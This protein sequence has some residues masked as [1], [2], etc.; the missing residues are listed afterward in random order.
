MSY[1]AP[2]PPFQVSQGERL[3][4]VSPSGQPP[5]F[6]HPEIMIVETHEKLAEMGAKM[7]KDL[8]ENPTA[9]INFDVT[10]EKVKQL[11]QDVYNR[12]NLEQK[13]TMSAEKI[14]PSTNDCLISLIYEAFAETAI[15]DAQNNPENILPFQLSI[16]SRFRR[17]P[18]VSRETLGNFILLAVLDITK[19][20]L[21]K[22]S[23][24]DLAFSM[25][26]RVLEYDEKYVQ[27]S[28]DKIAINEL[29]Q[30]TSFWHAFTL[31]FTNWNRYF[32][33]YPDSDLGQGPPEKFGT[34]SRMFVNYCVVK[35]GRVDGYLD[36]TIALHKPHMEKFLEHKN[37]KEYLQVS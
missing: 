4:H 21:A 16:N 8:I 31:R 18:P 19:D 14:Y 17:S 29:S 20:D 15:D 28:I 32:D 3:K 23:S 7:M 30:F 27:S 6:E 36:L 2:F 9:A 22:M 13:E 12:A 37:V 34:C 10:P 1:T 24:F 5:A 11:K 33:W 35:P 25:R 26:K